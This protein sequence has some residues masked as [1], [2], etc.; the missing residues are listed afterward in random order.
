VI[1]CMSDMLFL[2]MRLPYPELKVGIQL[3]FSSR[4]YSCFYIAF[5][6]FIFGPPAQ[7]LRVKILK[8]NK[9]RRQPPA[10]HSEVI[11]FWKEAAIFY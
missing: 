3:Q 7:S 6:I 5:E 1:A 8:L 2:C 4:R 9:N 10:F 11:V